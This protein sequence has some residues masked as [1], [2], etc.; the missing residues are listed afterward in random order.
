MGWINKMLGGYYMRYLKLFEN[1]RYYNEIDRN[2]YI[3]SIYQ[4]DVADNNNEAFTEG[5]IKQIKNTIQPIKSVMDPY[6]D[7]KIIINEVEL[8]EYKYTA[9]VI[10]NLKNQKICELSITKLEDEWFF[11]QKGKYGKYY[12]INGFKKF[13]SYMY[14]KCDQI[15]GVT[16]LIEDIL[17]EKKGTTKKR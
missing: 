16:E 14:F 7:D 9:K 3:N 1:T 12:D 6:N 13:K 17:L 2:D 15:S 11:V 10:V 4:S 5:E 8:N